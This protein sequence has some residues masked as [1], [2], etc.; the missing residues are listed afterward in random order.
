MIKVEDAYREM[1]KPYEK[2]DYVAFP[3]YIKKKEVKLIIYYYS[4]YVPGGQRNV[5]IVIPYGY[6]KVF[7]SIK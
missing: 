7:S 5:S 1:Y 4:E 6:D 2:Y 3:I